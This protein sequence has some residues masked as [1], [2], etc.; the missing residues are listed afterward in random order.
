MVDPRSMKDMELLK[1][2]YYKMYTKDLTALL[3][4]EMGGDLEKLVSACL[5]AAE[6]DY[7]PDFHT[8]EKAKEDAE[9][10]WKRGQGKF[11]G[12]NEEKLFKVIILSPP[13]YLKMVNDAYGLC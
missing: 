12:T 5:Q 8:P 10:I 9:E 6:E 2:T 4:S 13:K 3:M 7:D 1:K 11:F